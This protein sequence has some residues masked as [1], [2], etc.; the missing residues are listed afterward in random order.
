MST[1]RMDGGQLISAL[2]SILAA[3]ETA[4]RELL[5]ALTAENKALGGRDAATLAQVTSTKT[6]ALETLEKVELRRRELCSRIGAGPAQADM[7]AWLG[8]YAGDDGQEAGVRERWRSLNELMR[9]CQEMNQ[10]NGL[11]VAALQRRV[12]QALNLLRNGTTEP[13][14]YGPEG[15]SAASASARAIARA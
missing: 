1:H 3:E 5:E 4:A 6:T 10:A 12:R 7:D 2:D 15:G 11:V 9:Q 8:A 14:V 13:S